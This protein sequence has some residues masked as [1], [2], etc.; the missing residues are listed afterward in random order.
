M[1]S[2]RKQMLL[3]GIKLL[4]TKYLMSKTYK[5]LRY[6]V[7]HVKDNGHNNYYSTKYTPNTKCL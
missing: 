6:K 3:I 5:P 4:D 2:I 1:N 7:S